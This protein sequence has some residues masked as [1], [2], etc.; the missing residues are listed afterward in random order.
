MK[1]QVDGHIQ[2]PLHSQYINTLSVCL[3]EQQHKCCSAVE[4]VAVSR[5]LLRTQPTR[6][7][8]VRS[9]VNCEAQKKGAVNF[10]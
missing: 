9:F 7:T 2:N 6:S 3:F 10:G 8:G 5:D 4:T 1:L